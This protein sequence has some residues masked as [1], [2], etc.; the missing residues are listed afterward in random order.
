MWI[1]L[2]ISLLS[3]GFNTDHNIHLSKSEVNYDSQSQS[4]QVSIMLFL[5]D[6]E[7]ALKKGGA[8]DLKLYTNRET[9]DADNWIEAYL[10]KKLRFSNNGTP[11]TANYLGREIT[12]DFGGVWC[13]LEIPSIRS[14]QSFSVTNEIFMELFDDQRHV[15][16]IT[17]DHK[18]VD[19]WII[20]ED[21][22]ME[23]IRF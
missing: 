19:H 16:V 6:L 13:Y 3:L 22:Y 2:Y 4:V 9:V 18:R 5:D 12:E 17:K 7:A 21:P 1:F 23:Q 10:A 11:L 8:E 14:D 15:M 20:D